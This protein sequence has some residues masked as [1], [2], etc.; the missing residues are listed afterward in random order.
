MRNPQAG[1][2]APPAGANRHVKTNRDLAR[3]ASDCPGAVGACRCI[4]RRGPLLA[5]GLVPV[6]R[7][8]LAGGAG[9]RPG[10]RAA[11]GGCA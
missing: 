5:Q 6:N 11:C 8:R 9:E 7:C 10:W 1:I 3:A 4:Y 2:I